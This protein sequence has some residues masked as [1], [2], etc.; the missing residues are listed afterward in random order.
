M[1]LTPEL[2]Q[3]R[4]ASHSETRERFSH[5]TFDTTQQSLNPK[6]IDDVTD[7]LPAAR[8]LQQ[9]PAN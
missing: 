8:T 5:A 9:K 7:T 4:P 2:T 1:G 6:N 3:T